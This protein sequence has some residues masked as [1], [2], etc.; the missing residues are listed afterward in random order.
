MIRTNAQASNSLDVG[1]RK[2]VI[3]SE[4]E[5]PSRASIG[6]PRG[7]STPRRSARNDHAMR[8]YFQRHSLSTLSEININPAPPS[9]ALPTS[10]TDIAVIPSEVEG[11]P[12]SVDTAEACYGAPR[13]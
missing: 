11:P 6:T 4:V 2:P 8:R 3:P 5:G 1:Q 9:F 12:L 13:S 7:S 10:A